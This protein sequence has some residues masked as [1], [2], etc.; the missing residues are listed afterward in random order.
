LTVAREHV[1]PD[2]CHDVDE[3]EDRNK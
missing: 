1:G 3:E 2:N